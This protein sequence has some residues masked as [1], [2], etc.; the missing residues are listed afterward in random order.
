MQVFIIYEVLIIEHEE[1]VCIMSVHSSEEKA[2]KAILSYEK[3][4]KSWKGQKAQYYWEM[5]EVD[6]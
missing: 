1:R 4:A 2:N 3:A 6:S 5:Y